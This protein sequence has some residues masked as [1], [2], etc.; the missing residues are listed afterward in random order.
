MLYEESQTLTAELNP[1]HPSDKTISFFS[2]NGDNNDYLSKN[3]SSLTKASQTSLPIN[4]AK[5]LVQ[6]LAAERAYASTIPPPIPVS[7]KELEDSPSLCS[8]FSSIKLEQ[9]WLI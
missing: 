3:K 4:K 2:K 6:S 1:S 5:S 8:C 9:E 7:T